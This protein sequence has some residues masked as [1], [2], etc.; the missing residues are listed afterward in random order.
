M[1]PTRL[2][3]RSLARLGL[4]LVSTSTSPRRGGQ[5]LH[6]PAIFSGSKLDPTELCVGQAA[7]YAASDALVVPISKITNSLAQSYSTAGLNPLVRAARELKD[8]SIDELNY[9]KGFLFK[10]YSSFRPASAADLFGLNFPSLSAIPP[11]DGIAPWY[12]RL[13]RT[14]NAGIHIGPKSSSEIAHE[15]RRTLAV[16]QSVQRYGYRPEKFEDGSLRG[17]LVTREGDYRFILC[18]GLHRAAV[19]AAL[20]HEEVT[21]RFQPNRIWAV[22]RDQVTRWPQVGEGGLGLTVA[23]ALEWFDGLFD[24]DGSERRVQFG[25]ADRNG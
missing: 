23:E 15:Y 17:Y 21:A 20:D 5:T 24:R 13:D 22:D 3:Q 6:R 9:T 11:W 2:I 14:A 18:G 19:L 1:K 10:Y 16:M 12:T 4:Q 8:G 25:A 7:I